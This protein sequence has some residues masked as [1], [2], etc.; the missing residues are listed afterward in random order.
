MAAALHADRPAPDLPDAGKSRA[1]TDRPRA[2]PRPAPTD[3]PNNHFEYALT[4]FGLALALL[5]VYIAKLLR[6]RKA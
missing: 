5:G 2:R 4:W 3:I 1:R 6:D